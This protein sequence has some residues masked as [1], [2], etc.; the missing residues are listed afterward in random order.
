MSIRTERVAEL[1]QRELGAIFEKELP[2]NGALTTIMGVT[3]T[4]DLSIARVYLSI[5]G[6]KELG[7]SV[8]A[9]VKK[10][11]KF[12]RQELARKIKN[13]FRRMPDLEF[14]IDDVG[15]RAARIDQLLKEARDAQDA[16][17]P[18]PEGAN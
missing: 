15:E 2:R 14:F 5:I 16:N 4:P 13:Q 3:I 11:S 1:I 17:K 18:K 9:H 12:F 7:E 8:L 6:K 10:E